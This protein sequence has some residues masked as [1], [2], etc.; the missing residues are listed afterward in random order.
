MS[1]AKTAIAAIVL[2]CAPLAEAR[3]KLKHVLAVASH[4]TV[5]WVMPLGSSALASQRS[6][7]CRSRNDFFYCSGEY[8]S[9]AATESLRAGL[10]VTMGAL[11]EYGRRAGFREWYVMAVGDTIF[12]LVIAAK[13][14]EVHRGKR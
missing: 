1:A 7:V 3:P 4:V 13:S 9:P 11:S 6:S 14:S 10:S 5:T 12:N 8:A 2:L